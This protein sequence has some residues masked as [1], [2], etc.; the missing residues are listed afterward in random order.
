MR[1]VSDKHSREFQNT[2]FMFNN[3]FSPWKLYCSYEIMW[4]YMVCTG[5]RILC[6]H[7]ACWI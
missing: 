2:R 4:K 7:F 3:L 1:N 6:I 5:H